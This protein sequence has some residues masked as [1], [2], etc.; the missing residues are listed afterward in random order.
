M[1]A[2]G[3]TGGGDR[4]II[5]TAGSGYGD[6]KKRG[7]DVM[8]REVAQGLLTVNLRQISTACPETAI[9][10]VPIAKADSLRAILVS[11]S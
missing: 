11:G 3:R 7:R 9:F 8:L 4:L 6:P 10:S 2:K 5:E 1:G